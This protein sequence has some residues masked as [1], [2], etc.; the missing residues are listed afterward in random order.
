[1]LAPLLLLAIGVP[2]CTV[3]TPSCS[4]RLRVRYACL[5]SRT[6]ATVGTLAHLKNGNGNSLEKC[7][8]PL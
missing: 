7:E 3:A 4:R 6:P 8:L 2:W 1:M 5:R